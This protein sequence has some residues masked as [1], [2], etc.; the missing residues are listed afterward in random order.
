MPN[1]CPLCG[2]ELDKTADLHHLVPKCKKGTETVRLHKICH[3]KI[4]S[5]FDEK[6]LVKHYDTI[7]KLLE[8]EDIQRFI[9]WVAK[10]PIE[11]NDKSIMSNQHNWKRKR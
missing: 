11:Y 7:E 1:N 4:H 2:R 6:L 9:K 5:L 3:R 8:S 10:K